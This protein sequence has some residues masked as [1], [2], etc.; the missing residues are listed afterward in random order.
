MPRLDLL[1]AHNLGLS[2]GQVTRACRAGRVQTPEGE[3]LRDP[4]LKIAPSALPRTVLF[5]DSPVALRVRYHLLQHKPVGVVTALRDDRH[6][7]AYELVRGAPLGR[8]LRAVG[9]LDLDTSGLLLWTTEGALLHRLTH[10]RYAVRRTYQAALT[11]P[12]RAPPPGFELD[13]GHRPEILDL[14]A[15]AEA[16]VHPGLYVPEG[17]GALASI[18]IASGKFHE[19]RRI[20]AALG[21]EVLGLCRVSFG[22]LE[23]PRDLPAGEHREIDLH[24]LFAGTLHPAPLKPGEED[25]LEETAIKD[26]DEAGEDA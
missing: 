12:W 22:P 18:S 23:L 20:F 5:D 4:G 6:R 16:E 1:I 13:D 10:P 9:R 19:V 2:R 25:M 15:L 11:G 24:A 21:A 3:P 26:A 7:T 8:D 14:R 17:T